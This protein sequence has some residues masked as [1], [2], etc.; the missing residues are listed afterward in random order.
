[1]GVVSLI[2]ACNPVGDPIVSRGLQVSDSERAG[3]TDASPNEVNEDELPVTAPSTAGTSTNDVREDGA[4]PLKDAGRCPP[5]CQPDVPLAERDTDSDGILD[6]YDEDDDGDGVPDRVECSLQGI[7]GLVNG[8]FE[9]PFINELADYRMFVPWDVPGWFPV[10]EGAAIELWTDGHQ[11]FLA[12]SGRQFAELNV[13]FRT[14]LYQ[15]FVTAPLGKV[16]WAFAHR[17]RMGSDSVRI[18][19]G[20]PDTMEVQ[21]EFTTDVGEWRTYAGVY[22]VPQGQKQTR[23]M[24]EAVSGDGAGNLIDNVWVEPQCEVDSDQDGCVDSEDDD[25]CISE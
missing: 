13:D 5:P 12:A 4:S 15:D 6:V 19:L 24:L 9:V 14:A 22:S 25:N 7:A 20:T 11:G 2:A 21:G 8:D 10:P 16:R 23:I 17:G 1:V 18:L 3:K